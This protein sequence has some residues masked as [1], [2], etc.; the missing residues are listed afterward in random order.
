MENQIIIY[1]RNPD[2]GIIT[3]INVTGQGQNT[4][5]NTTNV[6]SLNDLSDVIVSEV[7]ASQT[8]MYNATNSKFENRKPALNDNSDISFTGL[9]NND[10]LQYNT[11]LSRW[12]NRAAT[13]PDLLCYIFPSTVANIGVATTGEKITN[14]INITETLNDFGATLVCNTF[15]ITGLTNALYRMKFVFTY[16]RSTS[17]DP[18]FYLE[19]REGSNSNPTLNTRRGFTGGSCYD[20]AGASISCCSMSIIRDYRVTLPTYV[21]ISFQN[22]SGQAAQYGQLSCNIVVERIYNYFN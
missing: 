6:S 8:I 15:R 17:A 4:T 20:P 5:I 3:P 18:A 22:E 14:N 2:T 1:G 21:H 16:N 10:L 9:L 13:T 19:Y 12:T 11:T 7:G